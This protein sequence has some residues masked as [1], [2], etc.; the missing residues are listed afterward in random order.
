MPFASP[1]RQFPADGHETVVRLA[2]AAI[3]TAFDQFPAGPLVV[4][5]VACVVVGAPEWDG[6]E[7][8]LEATS[9]TSASE[10]TVNAVRNDAA[11]LCTT[12]GPEGRSLRA[13][14]GATRYRA[15]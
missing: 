6:D 8:Q 15:Q 10:T 11:P 9:A 12:A 3:A 1:T 2:P 14:D 13:P 4:D 5:V 7:L